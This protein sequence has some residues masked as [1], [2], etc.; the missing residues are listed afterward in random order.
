M[1]IGV[2]GD[3]T[4][5]DPTWQGGKGKRIIGALNYLAAKG[6]NS[7]S[8]LPNNVGGDSDDVWPFVSSTEKTRC[9][10]SYIR[11]SRGLGFSECANNRYSSWVL[12]SDPS[13]LKCCVQNTPPS[14]KKC[15]LHFMYD[16]VL[17]V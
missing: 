9:R 4:D 11:T 1:M 8:F 15:K 13:T 6:V 16:W 12:L 14:V 10:H 3:Y 2:P 5:G 7:I 17:E